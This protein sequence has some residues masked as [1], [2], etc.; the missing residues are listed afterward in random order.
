MPV[1]ANE[2]SVRD[3]EPTDAPFLPPL[4]RQLGYEIKSDRLAKNI[5]AYSQ[6]KGHHAFV[7]E[8]GDILLGF[9]SLHISYWFHRPDPPARISALVVGDDYR[10]AGVGQRLVR[11]AEEVARKAGCQLIELTAAAYRRETGT[12][13]FYEAQGFVESSETATL[14]RKPL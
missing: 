3:A 6:L 5:S 9:L 10:G 8:S 12:H 1:S 11:R 13:A 14:F 4:L 7:A 2:V